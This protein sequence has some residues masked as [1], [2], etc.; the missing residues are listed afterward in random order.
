VA[1][2]S[3][4]VLVGVDSGGYL[5][6]SSNGTSWTSLSLTAIGPYSVTY[7]NSLYIVSGADSLVYTS[8][9]L[10]TWTERVAGSNYSAGSKDVYHLGVIGSTLYAFGQYYHNYTSTDGITWITDWPRRAECITTAA[11]TTVAAS[12]NSRFYVSTNSGASFSCYKLSSDGFTPKNIKYL[13]GPNKFFV[14]G[15]GVGL[16]N[17]YSS[18]DGVTWTSQVTSGIATTETIIHVSYVNSV[19]FASSSTGALYRSAT[20]NTWTTVT[21][22]GVGGITGAGGVA[23][24]PVFYANSVY[25]VTA[26]DA[27]GLGG[28]WRSTDGTT[29]ARLNPPISPCYVTYWEYDAGAV[30][31]MT[32]QGFTPDM[33]LMRGNSTATVWMV[34][35]G[36]GALN[37]SPA[38]ESNISYPYGTVQKDANGVYH[39]VEA[40]VGTHYMS[41]DGKNWVSTDTVELQYTLLD[42][43][44]GS[45]VLSGNYL[46]DATPLFD[47]STQFRVP[48]L[49]DKSTS[50]GVSSWILAA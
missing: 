32:F 19:Y 35:G 8:P 10:T 12:L 38:E 47:P 30:D 24:G 20:G 1:A 13:V 39:V 40:M 3:K 41:T 29:W 46:R 14:C 31:G 43:G 18:T 17:I 26:K 9:D 33:R 36:I 45:G 37:N 48:D 50:L 25:L 21:L 5:Q 4:W 7:F 11:G 44:V 6:H 49:L 34:E 27:S 2:T 42:M 28:F 15:N 16:P 23:V 22:P